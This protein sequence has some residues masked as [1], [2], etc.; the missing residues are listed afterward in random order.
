MAVV[1]KVLIILLAVVLAAVLI[2]LFWPVRY[3]LDGRLAGSGGS[4]EGFLRARAGLFFGLVRAACDYPERPEFT[5]KV[6][7]FTVFRTGRKEKEPEEEGTSE[8]KPKKSLAERVKQGC[9]TIRKISE[10]GAAA[11]DILESRSGARAW[12]KGRRTAIRFL[13]AVLPEK[14]RIAGNAGLGDPAA[15]G[16][17]MMAQSVLYPWTGERLLVLPDFDSEEIT[18]D[19]T[20]EGRGAFMIATVLFGLLALYLDKDVRFVWERLKREVLNGGE[21]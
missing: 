21:S 5:V 10:R 12:R 11:R 2:V 17:L 1:F 8:G 18:L 20:G 6:L 16:T 19:I 4:A 13:K 15:T 7:C 3:R 14:Y 9:D